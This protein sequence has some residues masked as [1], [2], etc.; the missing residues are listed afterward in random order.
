[1]IDYFEFSCTFTVAVHEAVDGD[2]REV[3]HIRGADLPDEP[4]RPHDAQEVRYLKSY[5]I[6]YCIALP[7][8]F[9]CIYQ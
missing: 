3:S 7:E 5:V 6:L 2:N 4:C 8:I 9:T 1:M